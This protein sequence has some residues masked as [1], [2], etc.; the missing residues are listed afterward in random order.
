MPQQTAGGGGRHTGLMMGDD[1]DRR[2]WAIDY[3]WSFLGT[4]YLWAGNDFA[5]FDC[6]GLI[7]E[8]LQGVGMLPHI[9]DGT[10]D[11]LYAK[12]QTYHVEHGYPGCLLFWFKGDKAIHVE[13]MVND[14]LCIGASGGGSATQ[15]REAAIRQNAFVKMRP[16]GYRGSGHKI[17]DPFLEDE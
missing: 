9:Y 16:I 4:P 10:A 14:Y 11:Q 7:I 6:S 15:T 5:G 2:E 13:M 12:F 17:V 1:K 3:L 8:V